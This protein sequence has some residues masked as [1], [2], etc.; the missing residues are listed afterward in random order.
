MS[1]PKAGPENKAVLALIEASGT[2][3]I[4]TKEILE[5][6]G[7]KM[8]SVESYIKAQ[9]TG[10][11]IAM[12]LPP[13]SQ[14][15]RY[16]SAANYAKL[17]SGNFRKIPPRS[18]SVTIIKTTGARNSTVSKERLAIEGVLK[19][20]IEPVPVDLIAMMADVDP[21]KTREILSRMQQDG[22]A[23]NTGG[24]LALWSATGK[25]AQTVREKRVC[26]GNQPDMPTGY[27]SSMNPVRPGA[28]DHLKYQSRGF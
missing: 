27:L 14:N 17:M 8:S 3:G 24:R 5:K 4:G 15:Q 18:T 11:K 23:R 1:A 22:T 6:T 21:P 20:A 26:N 12:A 9:R 2:K 19:A 13:G 28:E 16:V 25:V 7:Y 10:R